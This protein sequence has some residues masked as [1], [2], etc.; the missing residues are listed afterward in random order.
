[1]WHA[2]AI[3]FYLLSVLVYEGA[4]VAILVTGLLYA[5]LVG[6]RRAKPRWIADVAVILPALLV[7]FIIHRHGP[8]VRGY[9]R[10]VYHLPREGISAVLQAI[11]PV[12]VGTLVR[13][14]ILILVLTAV[15]LSAQSLAPVARRSMRRPTAAIAASLVALGVAWL[16]FAGAGEPPTAPGIDN[17]GNLLAG[18]VIALLVVAIAWL[19]WKIAVEGA[20][21]P[22]AGPAASALV[23]VS[24]GTGWL[25][26]ARSHT[27][28]YE[29]S[30]RSQARIL[31]GLRAA[32]PSPPA[33]A[34]IFSLASPALAA[35]GVPVFSETWDFNGAVK[36]LWNDHTLHGFPI[37]GEARLTCAKR[38]VVPRSPRLQAT[39]V[40]ESGLGRK[41]TAP[42]GRAFIYDGLTEQARRIDNQR[43]CREVVGT[44]PVGPI[45]PVE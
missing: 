35:P 21:R 8:G 22:W 41:Q 45:L 39:A 28:A 3:A 1:M 26:I 24:I 40:L 38:F 15:L 10:G 7:L 43:E 29:R 12:P 11:V 27:D 14:L 36:L 42:Y 37:V 9:V 33:G 31:A 19:C 16:P 23:L 2:G 25:L 4:G 32:L 5:A 34:T 20:P 44:I 30:A 18:F 6:W 17:R 13:A